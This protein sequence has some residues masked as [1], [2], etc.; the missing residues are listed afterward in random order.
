[1]HL[2]KVF[3]LAVSAVLALSAS[4][5]SAA[6]VPSAVNVGYYSD[7]TAKDFPPSK[8]PF[9][10]LT[11]VKYAFAVLDKATYE[12]KL[13]TGDILK[14]VVSLGH[15][16]N[17][18]VDLSV[19][20]W[21]GSRYFS[22][23]AASV[24]TRTAFVESVLKTVKEYNLDGIDLDWEFPGRGGN[25]CNVV[26]KENDSKNLLLLLKELRQK[27]G[28]EKSISMAVRVQ[29][30]DG[31][32]GPLKDVKE[33]AELLDYVL[34][35]AYDI[36]GR[37]GQTAGP[38]APLKYSS[39][40]G[41]QFSVTDGANAWSTAGFPAGKI[42][43]GVPFYGRAVTVAGA[44]PTNDNMYVPIVKAQVKG[45]SD[46]IEPTD[47]K[48]VETNEVNTKEADTCSEPE[49]S[50]GIW[51]WANLRSEG[52]LGKEYKVANKEWTQGWDSD[53]STPWIYNAA[54]KTLVSYDDP[55]SICLKAKFARTQYAGTMIWALNQDNGELMNA[56]HGAGSG[57]C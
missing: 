15:A 12:L 47:P 28:T 42:V 50:S 11:H 24:K 10:K 19:G 56:I 18:K 23:M 41:D 25:L 2:S 55:K 36:N 45:D 7:W 34:I 54:K 32:D 43:I 22:T 33:Y 14:E 52:V 51:K 39:K 5:V 17:V 46:D 9:D 49:E 30:F 35:M 38:N 1:M 53:T 21:T 3:P 57:A 16:N 31:P 6:T 26:D 13:D 29:P 27:L 8:I 44:A 48:E 20:G 40:G 4:I 37:W